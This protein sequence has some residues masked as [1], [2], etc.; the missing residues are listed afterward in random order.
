MAINDPK[1]LSIGTTWL[2]EL[3]PFSSLYPKN[4][5]FGAGTPGSPVST[6]SLGGTSGLLSDTLS[7]LSEDTLGSPQALA[8]A[9]FNAGQLAVSGTGELATFG[10]KN[11]SVNRSK[12][13][14]DGVAN[15]TVIGRTPK[16]A[17]PGVWC[18]LTSVDKNTGQKRVR[19]IG[20]ID[21]MNVS[22]QTQSNG[23]VTTQTSYKIRE[24]SSILKVPVRVEALT[25]SQAMFQPTPYN[26][27]TFVQN[28]LGEKVWSDLIKA[29]YNPFQLAV[30]CLQLLGAVSSNNS[31]NSIEALSKNYYET[32]ARMPVIPPALIKRLG[33]K[34]DNTNPFA[35]GFVKFING[36]R[37][38]SGNPKIYKGDWDG[39]FNK[40]GIESI[41]SYQ[42]RHETDNVGRPA[43]S[44]IGALMSVN[45][46]GW[47]ILTE[48]CDPAHNEF[49]TDL[50]YESDGKQERTQPVFVFRDKPFL[51]KKIKDKI[52]NDLSKFSLFDTLPRVKINSTAVIGFSFINTILNSPNLIRVDWTDVFTN[53]DIS[54]AQANARG[55]NLLLPEMLRH[56]GQE[57]NAQTN[58]VVLDP[59][60]P[61]SKGFQSADWW[62]KIRD[63]VTAW[64]S[65]HYRM[66]NGVLML[67]D[68]NAAISIGHNIEWQFGNFTLVG[69]VDSVNFSV[70]VDDRG[71]LQNTMQISVSRIV[72]K[73]NDELDFI[74]PD[75]FG[76]LADPEEEPKTP[77]GLEYPNFPSAA[78]SLANA[79]IPGPLK[80]LFNK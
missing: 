74:S 80:G 31:K 14:P 51:L 50:L 34:S 62:S 13:S 43:G 11:F 71:L 35:T 58:F 23:L 22:Y 41:D 70:I 3:F 73:I 18:L 47:D 5:E 15:L 29:S 64:H 48:Y 8:A 49:Y 28:K 67:K 57:Y 42:S 33:I 45:H 12:S 1:T 55:Y 20:Q 44:N 9:G 78:D 4:G 63:V 17:Y 30:L 54:K 61:E 7:A 75:Q 76:G 53:P 21:T 27:A 16:D 79:V 59:T 56:G 77:P 32:A 72:Q 36:V 6:P 68:Y 65:Y 37:K 40:D 24:W 39:V 66:G 69:H 26:A 60:S 19:F 46:T 38:D 10:L 25:I 52:P 2:W